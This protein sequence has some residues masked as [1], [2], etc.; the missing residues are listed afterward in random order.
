MARTFNGTNDSIEAASAPVTAVP[1]TIACW[2]YP[3]SSAGMAVVSLGVSG[4]SDRFQMSC[5]PGSTPVGAASVQSGTASQSS[6]SGTAALNQW[7]HAAAVFASSTSRTA[8]FNGSAATANTTASTP[9][10][11]NRLNISGRYLTTL[12]AFFQG[13]I[14]EVGIWNVALTADEITSLSKGFPCRLVRPSALVFY[15]RLIRNVMDIRN[16]V[17][18]SELGTGT[19]DSRHPRIIYPC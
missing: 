3:T 2:F 17:A 10:G 1:L 12:G 9:T 16:G 13:A 11:I 8:Y 5:V 19:T 15:S 14:A 4:G 7:H 6:F 18:L